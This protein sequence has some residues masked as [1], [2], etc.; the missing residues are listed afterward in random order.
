MVETQ[1]RRRVVDLSAPHQ[2]PHSFFQQLNPLRAVH[3]ELERLLGAATVDTVI[4][5]PRMFA[6][7]ALHW[8]APQIGSGDVVRWPYGAAE[9]APVDERDPPRWRHVRCSTPVQ[10]R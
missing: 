2:T 9:T 6:S 4:L 3:A 8:W 7:N 5:R 10:V 1:Q